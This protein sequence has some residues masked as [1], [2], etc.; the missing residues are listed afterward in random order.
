[1]V[2]GQSLDLIAE[3]EKTMDEA[4]LFRIHRRK[5]ADMLTA[6][7]LA[8]A[9]IAG[10]SGVQLSALERYADKL[11]LLFQITDDILD[12]EGDALLMGK[13]LGKDEKSNKLTF[14]SLY[15][16]DEAKETAEQIAV[17]ADALLASN[18]PENADY[19]RGMI[20]YIKDRKN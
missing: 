16:L 20:D 17:E 1:M 5:T 7:I 10:A 3:A 6:A 13:T 19:L 8:G 12:A 9:Y 11:G 14:V 4:M 15:G 2:A 18:F